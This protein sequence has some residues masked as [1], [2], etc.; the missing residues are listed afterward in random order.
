MPQGWM[1][2]AGSRKLQA[3][4]DYLHRIENAWK[5]SGSKNPLQDARLT[6]D[7]RT[8]A[9]MCIK[10]DAEEEVWVDGKG[11]TVRIRK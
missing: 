6:T 2:N 8:D 1:Q 7:S 9:M 4:S 3:E 10:E 5:N 11:Q